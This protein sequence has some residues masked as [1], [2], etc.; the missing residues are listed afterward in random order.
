MNQKKTK[1]IGHI[2]N[3]HNQPSQKALL[4]FV[5]LYCP[6]GFLEL[7]ISRL[8]CKGR[9]R[10]VRTCYQY[11]SYC[12]GTIVHRGTVSGDSIIC[13]INGSHP[14]IMLKVLQCLSLKSTTV[15]FRT[16]IFSQSLGEGNDCLTI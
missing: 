10:L 16:N 3:I 11:C 15:L 9:Q 1:R 14:L 4:E 12:L 7:Y 5:N 6:S 8:Y 13:F 2:K